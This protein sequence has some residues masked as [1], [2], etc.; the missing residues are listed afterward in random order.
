MEAVLIIIV[1]ALAG[2]WYSAMQAHERAV[3]AA[4]NGCQR[5]SLQL[6]DDTVVQERLRLK[7]GRDGRIH[8]QRRFEFEFL[9]AQGERAHGWVEMLGVRITA[10]QLEQAEGLLHD[11]H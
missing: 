7:R 1:A 10:V 9:G 8:F 6:L 2:Y 3:Q 4:R 11:V 5:Y